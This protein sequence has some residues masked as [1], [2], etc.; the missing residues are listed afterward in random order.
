MPITFGS[1]ITLGAGMFLDTSADTYVGTF[2]YNATPGVAFSS[3]TFPSVA[4]TGGG[5]KVIVVT[6][7]ACAFPIPSIT[8]ATIAGVAATVYAPNPYPTHTGWER[9]EIIR[10]T[11]VAAQAGNVVLN[12]GTNLNNFSVSY[13]TIIRIHVYTTS[14]QTTFDTASNFASDGDNPVILTVTGNANNRANA[15]IIVGATFNQQSYITGT[16]LTTNSA[17]YAAYDT[18]NNNFSNFISA[19]RTPLS[20]SLAI[21]TD[22]PVSYGQLSVITIA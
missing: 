8:S 1:G 20:T 11:G 7:E 9:C 2:V 17:V 6:Y 15:F 21:T 22:S 12:F 5:T 3:Y 19:S 13:F 14:K 10:V 4:L 16:G 18:G